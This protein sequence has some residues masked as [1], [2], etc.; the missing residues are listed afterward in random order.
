M[1]KGALTL[2]ISLAVTFSVQWRFNE[3]LSKSTHHGSH[4]NQVRMFATDYAFRERPFQYDNTS[5]YD[6]AWIGSENGQPALQWRLKT[7]ETAVLKVTR[8]S[9]EVV[10]PG[11]TGNASDYLHVLLEGPALVAPLEVKQAGQVF[12]ATLTAYDV[13]AYNVHIEIM[14]TCSQPQQGKMNYNAMKRIVEHPMHLQVDKGKRAGFPRKRCQ[15]FRWRHG[16][17]MECAHTPLPCV[18]TGW[19]W[20]PSSCHYEIITPYDMVNGDPTWIVFAGSSVERGSFLSLVDYVLDDRARNLTV[21]D[22]WKC[23]GWSE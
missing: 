22:F 13:G 3:L 6:I 15:D 1:L 8:R 11:C 5:N 16:R 4:S 19:V 23:W 9:A 17:W 2:A 18:R 10:M 12:I 7:G 14:F 21:S 20:V